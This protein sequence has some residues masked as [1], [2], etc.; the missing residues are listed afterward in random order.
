MVAVLQHPA[1]VMGGAVGEEEE[2]DA[3][4]SVIDGN[5]VED[6]LC[7]ADRR[8][9][10]L[11]DTE[12]SEL[13]VVDDGVAA[14]VD[15]SN[16]YRSLDGN[17]GLRVGKVLDERMEKMLSDPFFWRETYIFASPGTEDVILAVAVH[18]VGRVGQWKMEN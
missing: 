3:E 8:C 14:F 16:G 6:L 1:G 12:G 11:D 9:F 4:S 17:E 5:L 15:L 2:G 18:Y 10:E 7:E 13:G